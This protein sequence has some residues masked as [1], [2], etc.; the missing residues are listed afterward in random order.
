MHMNNGTGEMRP[1]VSRASE[2]PPF[3][4]I[5]SALREQIRSGAYAAGSLLPSE[6]ELTE[7]W[8]VSSKTIRAAL[9][10]LRSEGLII[11]RQGV[12]TFVREQR[13]RRQIST[14]ITNRSRNR[15]IYA[16]YE[17]AGLRPATTTTVDRVPAPADVAEALGIEEATMV[18]IRDRVVRAE[19]QPADMIERSYIPL[20]IVDAAPNL[21]R[22]DIGGMMNWIE[23]A[24]Y[25]PLW[26]EDTITSRM[27][28]QQERETLDMPPGV[29][30]T[31]IVG[32]TLAPDGRPLAYYLGI[33]PG[34]RMERTYRYGAVPAMEEAESG[35]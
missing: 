33:L 19:G 23:D 16:A 21:A 29:P 27:P 10:Q 6:R 34:D 25:G 4:Q 32:P 26:W 1:M 18:L 14:D 11:S 31:V 2:Q 3:R 20:D 24:G 5:A 28:T 35:Q 17:R 22:P 30:V 8:G 12:G 7:R 13:A 9:D 15:G